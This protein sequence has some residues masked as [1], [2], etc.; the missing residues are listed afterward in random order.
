[1]SSVSDYAVCRRC[2]FDEASHDYNCRTFEEDVDCPACGYRYFK[3]ARWGSNKE[4]IG[5]DREELN[6]AGV[7]W[8]RPRKAIACELR[9][10]N[11][12][13]DVSR[14][15]RLLRQDLED[16]E[17]ESKDCYLARWNSATNQMDVIIGQAF[18]WSDYGMR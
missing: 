12:E 17:V 5:Y 15:E 2:H 9:S 13:E 14:V 7:L 18:R 11:T 1:M 3:T 16:G 8:I 4:L 6:P 10:L